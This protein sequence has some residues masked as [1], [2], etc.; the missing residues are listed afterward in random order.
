M[1]ISD[2]AILLATLCRQMY[3]ATA[4]EE[5]WQVLLE[6]ICSVAAADVAVLYQLD[7]DGNQ[8]YRLLSRGVSPTPAQITIPPYLLHDLRL[9]RQPLQFAPGQ[10]LPPL[11][12]ALTEAIWADHP[13][14]S[15]VVLPF[16]EQGIVQVLCVCGWSITI[17]DEHVGILQFLAD[18]ATYALAMLA[19]AEHTNYVNG[20]S[21]EAMIDLTL[22]Y[23]HTLDQLL[24]AA[25]EHL[26]VSGGA[27]AGAIYLCDDVTHELHLQDVKMHPHAAALTTILRQLWQ[28]D[29][30][31]QCRYLADSLLRS[32]HEV[33]YQVP[34]PSPPQE[35]AALHTFFRTYAI[36]GVLSIA[37]L[38]GGWQAGVI[39]LVPW[40]GRGFSERQWQWLRLLVRQIGV[41]IEHS[42]LFE[43]LRTELDRA[44]AVVESTNDGIIM[45]SPQ[46]KIVMVNRRACYFLGIAEHDL[47]GHSYDDL[48]LLFGRVFANPARLTFWLSQLLASETDRAQEEF[49]VVWPKPRRLLCF[50]APVV[51]DRREQYLGRILI[52]RDVTHERE[53][54]QMKNEFVSTV[55]H[56]LR[57]PLMNAQGSL[58][59]ILGDLER[60][61]PGLVPNMPAKAREL[62]Q[63]ALNNTNRL[64]RLVNDMLDIAKIERGQLQLQRKPVAP[65]E[66][67]RSAVDNLSSVA[68]QNDITIDVEIAPNLPL[69]DVDRD[70][71]V[72]VVVNLLSN[73]IKF[74]ASGQHVLLSVTIDQAMVRFSVRDWG[75]GISRSD[76]E[77]LFKKFQQLDQSISRQKSGSGLGLAISRELVE[78]HGG[79]IWVESEVGHGSTFHFTVPLARIQRLPV[80]GQPPLVL[81]GA[82]RH[83][84]VAALQAEGTATSGWEIIVRS[85][86]ELLTMLPE[87]QPAV[88]VLSHPENVDELLFRLRAIPLYQMTPMIVVG[89]ETTGRLPKDVLFLAEPIS[90]EQLIAAVREQIIRP[91]PLIM[92]VD[93]D[94]NVRLTLTKVLQRNDFRVLSASSG[95]EALSLANHI[96]PH[97]I[98][99][100]LRMPEVDGFEVLRRLRANPDT[101]T[102][103]VV[104][105]TA[106]DL[107]P[108]AP[109]Q[110]SA[111][112]ANGF[113]EKPVSADRLIAALTSVIAGNEGH[114]G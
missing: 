9:L 14:T 42:R 27:A 31:R 36:N 50:S 53:V 78:L 18:D 22:L 86:V 97:A 72:Q 33:A 63:I 52:F 65:E 5:V 15:V 85:P 26:V 109:I 6:G 69:I 57:T 90:T 34:D 12:L 95:E 4:R 56:E 68:R 2:R 91:K 39:Q 54:E 93:D 75:P 17:T 3:R 76:Q 108:D 84:L 51:V 10:Q 66:I 35:L 29:L 92:V 64:L 81:V 61:K 45:I 40:P 113:L 32:G 112:G 77:K 71:I 21:P 20:I 37:I 94:P 106:N 102:I 83:P 104:V 59:L 1:H 7:S 110:A 49:Q 105:L 23:T 8:L 80:S 48:L 87:R 74:S 55:S 13:P 43:Q 82:D 58:Q 79:R 111:L 100:D 11:V 16:R 89:D 41:A 60:G 25:L 101:T 30:G 107:G 24:E 103:P 46:R 67:C 19:H 47:K 28:P 62:L 88:V 114:H 96:R 70:R 98:L 73:A 38:V 44:Q 99:L